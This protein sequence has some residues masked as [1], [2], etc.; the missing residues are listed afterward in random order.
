MDIER[1][2]ARVEPPAAG[3]QSAAAWQGKDRRERQLEAMALLADALGEAAG[4]E[5]PASEHALSVSV[6][7]G[8]EAGEWVLDATDAPEH[9]ESALGRGRREPNAPTLPQPELPSG[10]KERDLLA[11][12]RAHVKEPGEAM[13]AWYQ[14]QL[15]ADGAIVGF[16]ALLRWAKPGGGFYATAQVIPMA[17]SAGVI[18]ALDSWMLGIV[19]RQT[20]DWRRRG[21]LPAGARVSL[22]ISISQLLNGAIEREAVQLASQG[23]LNP[24]LMEIEVDEAAVMERFEESRL[25]LERLSLMGFSIALDNFGTGYI[26]LP[27]LARLPLRRVKVDRS[28]VRALPNPEAALVVSMALALGRALGAQILAEG[29]ESA[30]QARWLESRDVGALQGFHFARPMSAEALEDWREKQPD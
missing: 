13:A 3:A 18:D 25:A 22:N 7:D 27:R 16:E 6:P 10:P 9:A 23:E 8:E 12:L 1:G 4:V 19:A 28:L 11:K 5:P 17:E 14:P 15:A 29:V 26:S 24:M 20:Q 21:V 2:E 30:E